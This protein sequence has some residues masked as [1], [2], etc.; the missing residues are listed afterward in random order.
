[1]VMPVKIASVPLNIYLLFHIISILFHCYLSLFLLIS[2]ALSMWH[3]RMR[4]GL[5]AA[6]WTGRVS[7]PPG[8]PSC[9]KSFPSRLKASVGQGKWKRHEASEVLQKFFTLIWLNL[10]SVE[11]WFEEMINGEPR[12]KRRPLLW[13][14]GGCSKL[15]RHRRDRDASSESAKE[16]FAAFGVAHHI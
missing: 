7:N 16:F 12:D 9:S 5:F 8:L 10:Q 1:M 11:V 4:A 6:W 13:H 2:F 3:L 15:F 14:A